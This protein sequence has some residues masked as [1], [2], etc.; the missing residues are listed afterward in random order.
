MV[1]V[2]ACSL[3]LVAVVVV[4]VLAE[5]EEEDEGGEVVV[6]L[7]PNVIIHFLFLLWFMASFFRVAGARMGPR[8]LAQSFRGHGRSFR[9]FHMTAASKSSSNDNTSWR[10]RS[11]TAFSASLLGTSGALYLWNSTAG[12]PSQCSSSSVNTIPIVE[13][14]MYALNTAFLFAAG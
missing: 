13:I 6:L 2:F 9:K 8:A 4:L 1:A 12:E 5:D 7:V 3:F 11:A 10:F 14:D